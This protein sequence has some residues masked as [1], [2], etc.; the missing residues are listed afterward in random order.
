MSLSHFVDH[1][2]LEQHMAAG[3]KTVHCHREM[4]RMRGGD[5]DGVW[6]HR[7]QHHFVIAKNRNFG[8]FIPMPFLRFFDTGIIDIGKGHKCNFRQCQQF[9]DMPL[10][11][12]A[13]TNDGKF[14]FLSH[15]KF[16][17]LVP[18]ALNLL[19]RPDPD[20]EAS[21]TLIPAVAFVL[22]DPKPASRHF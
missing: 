21:S 18:S 1:W 19:Q 15:A 9:F 6:L 16:P 13:S 4:Q 20:R 12:T 2:L 22:S 5:Q 7:L 11:H 17:L 10:G 8:D 3:I 14:H